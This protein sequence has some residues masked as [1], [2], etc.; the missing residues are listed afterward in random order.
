MLELT[1]E[2]L[3]HGANPNARLLKPMLRGRVGIGLSGAT[4]LLLAAAAG[5]V[6]AMSL[7]V[8][9]GADPRLGTEIDEKE[10][11]REGTSD[12]GQIQA[13]RVTPLMAAAGMGRHQNRDRYPE[14]ERKALEAVKVLV[15][16]GADVNEAT[17][18]GWTPL[19]AA[20]F[21]GANTIVQFLVDKGAKIDAANG[22]GQTP[23]TLAEGSSAVGLRARTRLH[24]STAEL[25]YELGA[26]LTGTFQPTPVGRCVLGRF[27]MDLYDY[28]PFRPGVVAQEKR[29]FQEV[30]DQLGQN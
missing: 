7:L 24:Q 20:A 22:C 4:P 5:D 27:G 18:T 3:A 10:L 17:E 15:G 23:L 13:G 6:T 12:G 21:L 29:R 26:S 16:L 9:R 11:F 30:E 14:D 1:K 19:H 2:L 8:E 25:L 28:E